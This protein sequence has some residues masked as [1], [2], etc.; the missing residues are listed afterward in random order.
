MHSLCNAISYISEVLS[1]VNLDQLLKWVKGVHICSLATLKSY[2]SPA[3]VQICAPTDKRPINLV[4]AKLA[5]TNGISLLSSA[6]NVLLHDQLKRADK[7]PSR[8]LQKFSEPPIAVKQQ[9]F[10]NEAK[11]PI[12]LLQDWLSLI[13]QKHTLPR[14]TYSQTDAVWPSQNKRL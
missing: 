10:V 7:V 8:H 4:P 11:T 9:E 3:F 12:S 6:S 1:T 2:N 14:V 5:L 13:E